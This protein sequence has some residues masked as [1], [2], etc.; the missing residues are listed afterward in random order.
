MSPQP[1]PRSFKRKYKKLRAQFSVIQAT[2][3]VLEA[4][5]QGVT[6]TALKL[7][8]DK[9]MILDLLLDL[10]P[11]RQV[12]PVS[13][14]IAS[15]S[16]PLRDD[17]YKATVPD[18][19]SSMPW[20]LDRVSFSGSYLEDLAKAATEAGSGT[21]VPA[22]DTPVSAASRKSAPRPSLNNKKRD[23]SEIEETN[24]LSSKKKKRKSMA[25]PNKDT[26]EIDA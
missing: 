3:A 1:L 2:T 26:W 14:Q 10:L 25:I 24:G 13:E 15:E 8:S 23:R 7:T 22:V 18:H 4:E 9:D 12:T 19:F 17:Y 5:L 11:E 21:T 6:A 16:N 20:D